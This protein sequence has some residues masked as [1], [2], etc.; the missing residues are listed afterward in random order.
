MTN[1]I[2]SA[3]D[4]AFNRDTNLPETDLLVYQHTLTMATDLGIRQRIPI[5][6]TRYSL[7]ADVNTAIKV[8]YV[9]PRGSLTF[10]E[11][12]GHRRGKRLRV[13]QMILR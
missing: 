13:T 5:S 10:T 9:E 4:K 3:N 8:L 6:P 12:Q 2:K 1:K 11:I 7:L